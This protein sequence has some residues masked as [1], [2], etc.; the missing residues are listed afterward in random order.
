MLLCCAV[1]ISIG[2]MMLLTIHNDEHQSAR[3]GVGIV[4][5]ILASFRL[6]LSTRKIAR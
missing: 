3:R 6:F 4:I 5:L 2:L 1:I